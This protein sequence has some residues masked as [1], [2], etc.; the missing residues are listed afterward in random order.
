MHFLRDGFDGVDRAEDVAGM[1]AGYE[2][3]AC[4]E[5]AVEGLSVQDRVLGIRGRPP[6]DDEVLSFCH[7]DPWVDVGLMVEFGQ[8]NLVSGLE[9]KGEG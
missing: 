3:S 1:S 7:A 5:Q 6:F 8:Y 4:G 2:F 9:F